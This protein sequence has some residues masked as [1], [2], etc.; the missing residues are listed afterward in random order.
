[1]KAGEKGAAA[2]TSTSARW[3]HFKPSRW[4]Q[5]KPSLSRGCGGFKNGARGT[6]TPDLLGAIPAT[7]RRVVC[8]DLDT[9]LEPAHA[10]EEGSTR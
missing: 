3:G 4:G 6:R 9:R 7:S 8:H 10:N 5:A 2:R 1:M